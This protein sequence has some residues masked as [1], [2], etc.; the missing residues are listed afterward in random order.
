MIPTISSND[1]II[2]LLL[3][4]SPGLE[5]PQVEG[6]LLKARRKNNVN[7]FQRLILLLSHIYLLNCGKPQTVYLAKAELSI[8]INTYYECCLLVRWVKRKTGFL[9]FLQLLFVY[10]TSFWMSQETTI[11]NCLQSLKNKSGTFYCFATR[12][13]MD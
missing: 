6:G 9:L 4:A 5:H 10:K 3:L 8:I 11:A 2:I 7:I 1:I 12:N 13:E